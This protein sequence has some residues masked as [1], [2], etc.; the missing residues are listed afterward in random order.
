M[1]RDGD[2]PLSVKSLFIII[3]VEKPKKPEVGAVQLRFPWE[4]IN[5]LRQAPAPAGSRFPTETRPDA[6]TPEARQFQD[7]A[8]SC[9][10]YGTNRA[11]R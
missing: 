2:D 7:R 3:K 9:R 4:R 1:C 5:K 10:D 8:G 11:G 6:F